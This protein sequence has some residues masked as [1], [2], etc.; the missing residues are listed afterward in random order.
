MAAQTVTHTTSKKGYLQINVRHFLIYDFCFN[1]SILNLFCF[2][3]S[4]E[5]FFWFCCVGEFVSFW[6]VNLS[7]S[8]YLQ[9]EEKQSLHFDWRRVATTVFFG[10]GFVGPAG[11]FW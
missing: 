3:L 5:I 7:L 2:F 10:I 1:L 9:E 6:I 8:L 4:F 11:H